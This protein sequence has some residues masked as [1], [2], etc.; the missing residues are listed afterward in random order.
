MSG[1]SNG[2][3]MGNGGAF[4]GL[5]LSNQQISNQQNAARQLDQVVSF[6]QRKEQWFAEIDKHISVEPPCP[7]NKLLNERRLER[8]TSGASKY[9][10]INEYFESQPVY[11][12]VF[13][14]Q[15]SRHKTETVG[16]GKIIMPDVVQMREEQQACLGII[17][18]AG[19]KALDELASHGMAPGHLVHFVRNLVFRIPVATIG[20][21][22]FWLLVLEAGD[23]VGSCDL[24]LNIKERRVRTIPKKLEDGSVQHVHCD[25]NGEIWVPQEPFRH[26]T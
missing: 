4:A 22:D 21:K 3:F 5:A 1:D 25:E 14:A 2:A 12:R 26:G 23:I 7:M 9:M 18:G 10:L 17:V 6:E 13:V 19:L 20:G 24:A 8:H 16:D 11:D 15:V